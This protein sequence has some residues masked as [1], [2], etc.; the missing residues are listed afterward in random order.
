MAWMKQAEKERLLAE[1]VAA[2]QAILDTAASLKPA[3][4]GRPFLGTWTIRE[5]LAHLA[6]WDYANLQAAEAIQLGKLPEFYDH[7]DA[8][9]RSYNEMAVARYGRDDWAAMLQTVLASHR[10]LV[11][12][13]EALP[14]EVFDRDFGVRF[15]GYKVTIARLLA[16]EAK[17][18]RAHGQQV[19]DFASIP[20]VAA[21]DS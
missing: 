14:A 21:G 8:D 2:R 9:W 16:A 1:L 3:Q 12:Y 7:R 15:R 5:V 4:R 20:S 18:E 11:A 6:G 17:D 19:R 10:A 13:L